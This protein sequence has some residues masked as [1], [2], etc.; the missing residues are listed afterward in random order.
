M[1][2]TEV[3]PTYVLKHAYAMRYVVTRL[4]CGSSVASKQHLPSAH[5]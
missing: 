4:N 3:Q 1:Y 2:H 5:E